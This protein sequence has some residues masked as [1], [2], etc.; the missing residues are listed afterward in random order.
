MTE[1]D[2][3]LVRKT[4]VTLILAHKLQDDDLMK[5]APQPVWDK[6]LGTELVLALVALASTQLSEDD[7]RN[8]LLAL[9]VDAAVAT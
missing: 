2:R 8:L 5:S 1:V 3:W 6:G 9:E 4:A 7:C